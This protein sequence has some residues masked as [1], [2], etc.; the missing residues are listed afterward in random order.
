MAIAFLGNITLNAQEGGGSGSGGGSCSCTGLTCSASKTCS[1]KGYSC[2][3]TCTLTVCSCT[4]CNT[5]HL[6]VPPTV[7]Q[8]Q[9]TNRQE[10]TALLRSFGSTTANESANLLDESYQAL[11]SNDLDNYISKGFAGEAKL[12][13]L[14]QPEKDA[15][16]AWIA[17]K[18]SDIRI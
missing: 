4:D 17:S 3:C 11:I 7:S 2:N 16:N 15:V 9:L 13:L 5:S 8:E 1:V 18:G 14:T 6:T 12:Q 10:L